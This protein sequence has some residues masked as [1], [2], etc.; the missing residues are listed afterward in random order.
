K[1]IQSASK[2]VLY[3]AVI[4]DSLPQAIALERQITNL[5]T[6]A[7]VESMAPFLAENQT[8]KLR[9]VREIKNEV[10]SIR[11]PE[12]DPEPVNLLELTRTL[13]SLQGYLGLASE[14]V[15]K[16]NQPQLYGQL[17]SLRQSIVTLREQ[18]A[19]SDAKLAAVKLAA[20]QR[21]LFDDFGDTFQ[22]I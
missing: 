6:V 12:P 22:T 10:A 20:F 5:T 13:W 16:E 11:F 18:L 14:E 4:A 3:A 1:L 21:A 17:R 7:S 2:S 8:E 9:L 15:Q 19:Y